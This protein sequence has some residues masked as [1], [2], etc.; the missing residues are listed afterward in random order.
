MYSLTINGYET[1]NRKEDE[2]AEAY[3]KTPSDNYMAGL[4]HE[5]TVFLRGLFNDAHSVGWEYH[6]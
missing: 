3:F 5:N 1:I 6:R 2:V 4:K